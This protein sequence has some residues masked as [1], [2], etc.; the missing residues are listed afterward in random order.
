MA[1]SA[2]ASSLELTRQDLL[3]KNRTKKTRAN[4][5]V[6]QKTAKK[7]KPILS[8][9]ER[10][11]RAKNQFRI[12]Q[13]GKMAGVEDTEL[14]QSRTPMADVA[15]TIDP[16]QIAR[17]AGLDP[18]QMSD[19][20]LRADMDEIGNK[21]DLA[22]PAPAE[23]LLKQQ[24]VGA[25]DSKTKSE[26]SKKFREQA[27]ERLEKIMKAKMKK[28]AKKLAIKTG[29]HSVKLI[30]DVLVETILPLIIVWVIMHVQLIFGNFFKLNLL[31]IEVPDLALWEICL[32]LLIDFGMVLAYMMQFLLILVP[33]MAPALQMIAINEFVQSLFGVD[34]ACSLFDVCILEGATE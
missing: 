32:L 16:A 15:R 12:I 28:Y 22:G 26:L 21:E 17:Q 33:I 25:K 3:L 13:G 9:Q 30:C 2:A 8:K 6:P 19:Q 7:K 1:N 23:R 10:L 4:L 34:I 27:K 24:A 11:A 31:G 29:L 14:L 18:N 5:S 20:G